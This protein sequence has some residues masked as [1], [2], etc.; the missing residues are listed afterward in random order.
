VSDSLRYRLVD[1]PRPSIF[2]RFALPPLLVFLVATYFLP[3]GLL[4][5]AANAIA[6]N[7]PHR[8]REVGFAFIP[9]IIYFV[10]IACLDQAVRSSWL[11]VSQANYVFVGALGVGLVFAAAAFVSQTQTADLRQYLR[12]QA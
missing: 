9:I 11:A 1:E 5:V 2:Q 10:T 8:N 3:W 12:Q 4:L 6:L 7:G